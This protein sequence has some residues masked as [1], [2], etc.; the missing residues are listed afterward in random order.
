LDIRRNP[1]TG[2]PVVV[3]PGRSTRPGALGRTTR[4]ADAASCP[5]CEGHEAMTPP[6]VLAL[7]RAGGEHDTPG[8]TVRVVPNKF[9]AIPGQEVVVHGPEHVTAFAELPFGVVTTALEA[10]MQRRAHAERM[11]GG[12]AYLLAAVNEGP[13]AGASLDHSHS[14]LV[15]FADIPPAVAAEIPAFAAP[16]ALCAAAAGEGDRTVRLA[17]GMRT[18]A[19]GWGR[20]AYELWIVPEQ[21][22]GSPAD[23]EALAAALLDATRRLRA[24]LGEELAW[25]A[26]LHAAP[27]RGG[28]PFHWHIEI[29]PRL[30]VAASVE[31][32]AGIW[33]NIVDPGT[34]AM[35][36]RATQ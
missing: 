31:L 1:L 9:P 23:P 14:Q 11:D 4:I 20:F 6:E 24:V 21:H 29:W 2:V 22:T 33:V 13:A 30:T 34:A 35:E 16:C 3:A 15:P 26:V 28:D 8:W 5:F 32:G 25:N 18:F 36:L 19:P 7:G 17:D 27:L 12:P 10:W